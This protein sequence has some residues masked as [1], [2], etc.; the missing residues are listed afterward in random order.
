MAAGAEGF[1]D[2]DAGEEVAARASTGDED[3]Q[4]LGHDGDAEGADT[5]V[6]TRRTIFP[7]VGGNSKTN[8]KYQSIANAD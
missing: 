1:G 4:R 8:L 2:G 6:G 3:F 7:R 5:K